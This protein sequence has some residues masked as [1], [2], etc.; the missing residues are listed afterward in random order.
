MLNRQARRSFPIDIRAGRSDK[1]LQRLSFQVIVHRFNPV[2]RIKA[3]P[4]PPV[5]E[6]KRALLRNSLSPLHFVSTRPIF[7]SELKKAPVESVSG[8]LRTPLIALLCRD[9]ILVMPSSNQGLH[10]VLWCKCGAFMGLR[11]PFDNWSTDRN[12]MCA[13]CTNKQL[14]E[15]L[16]KIPE[17]SADLRNQSGNGEDCTET[18]FAN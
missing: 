1:T 4:R 9:A 17:N 10:M 7:V 12:G 8:N 3:P 14:V 6:K 16:Q 18:P 15:T 5:R 11:E 13:D 2:Q